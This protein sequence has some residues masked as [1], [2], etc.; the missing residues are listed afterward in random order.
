MAAGTQGDSDGLALA[1]RE[2]LL[3]TDGE[4][5][6]AEG[7]AL[8]ERE[9][10]VLSEPVAEAEAAREPVALRVGEA[11][12]EALPDTE[13]EGEP[14]REAEPDAVALGEAVREPLNDRQVRA[15]ARMRLLL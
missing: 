7:E 3:V 11:P 15:A 4:A 12:R 1:L 13:H 6:E 10:E 8:R 5:R 14:A 2:P 9:E